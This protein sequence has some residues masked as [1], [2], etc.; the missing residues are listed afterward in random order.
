[1]YN[2]VVKLLPQ[3]LVRLLTGI[4][5]LC[6]LIE[7]LLDRL[8]CGQGMS[9]IESPSLFLHL[10]NHVLNRLLIDT[11]LQKYAT[12]GGQNVC[13]VY[14]LVIPTVQWQG[15]VVGSAVHRWTTYGYSI[16]AGSA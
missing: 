4:Q 9:C 12:S 16:G 13:L 11:F 1:M 14:Y 15:E 10:A 2:E 8:Q 7:G 6:V 3:R 5:P